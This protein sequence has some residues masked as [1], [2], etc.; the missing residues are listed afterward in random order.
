MDPTRLLCAWNSPGKNTRV[1]SHSLLHRNFLTQG[2]NLDLLHCRQIL[3]HLNHQGSSGTQ[4]VTD[5]L[6][7]PTGTNLQVR[8]L[9]DCGLG[10]VALLSWGLPPGN[11]LGSQG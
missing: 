7:E 8:K 2:L 5:K 11:V 3:Y 10:G 4:M 9:L 1:V 6:L